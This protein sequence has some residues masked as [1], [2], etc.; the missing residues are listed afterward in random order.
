VPFTWIG[1]RV[2]VTGA[3]GFIGSHLAEKLLGLG[4]DVTAIVH[5]NALGSHGNLRYL[6]PEAQKSIKIAAGNVED[7]DY[8]SS[9]LGN[10]DVV[11]H[12]AALIAIP[13]SYVAPRSYLRTNVEG[14]LNVLEAVRRGSTGLAIHTSTSE[15]YG[16]AIR[17][18]IDEDH[19]LQGQSPY[20]A[21]KIGADKLVESY[22]RS[23]GT[24]VITIRP[25][26]TYGPRQSARAVIPTIISQ[27]FEQPQIQLGALDPQRDL[28]Y[29]GDTVEGF[30][31]AAERPELAGET[32]N[33]GTGYTESVGEIVQRIQRLMGTQKPVVEDTRRIRPAKSE[34]MKLVSDNRKALRLMGWA[35]RTEL[36]EGL[37]RTIQSVSANPGAYRSSEYN[38]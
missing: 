24:R 5:Y 6:S 13:F 17:D 19:P 7:G 38:V 30:L 35:P 23:F 34:V 3:G 14:T 29:V 25:F 28:T 36:D 16:T 20:S 4:A 21:S 33:L 15:V 1:K 11:F 27:A 26:N 8:V 18:P 31:A 22:W 12:L 10:K 37:R 32:I 2:V 9:V